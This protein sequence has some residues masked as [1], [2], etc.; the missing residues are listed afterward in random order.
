[1]AHCPEDTTICAS[2]L[3]SSRVSVANG[4]GSLDAATV[5]IFAGQAAV[6]DWSGRSVAVS[7]CC[8]CSR[9]FAYVD[10]KDNWY[11]C[12]CV[13][14]GASRWC[15]QSPPSH[16]HLMPELYKTLRNRHAS[17]EIRRINQLISPDQGLIS[18]HEARPGFPPLSV[19]SLNVGVIQKL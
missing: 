4:S 6:A 14:N 13:L 15:H 17:I 7:T 9:P 10:E 12:Q 5:A 1:M 8:V 18:D 2:P 3:G 16:K 11:G 19:S